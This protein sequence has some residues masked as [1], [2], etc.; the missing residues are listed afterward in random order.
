MLFSLLQF[1]VNYLIHFCLR[2]EVTEPNR[3]I[4]VPCVLSLSLLYGRILLC[5]STMTV[6]CPYYVKSLYIC[7]WTLNAILLFADFY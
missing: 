2:T 3:Q 7:T 5:P 1:S 6:I 4:E